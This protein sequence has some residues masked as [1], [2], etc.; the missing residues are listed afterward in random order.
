VS[1]KG[2]EREREH[3]FVTN[4]QE[5]SKLLSPTVNFL[6]PQIGEKVDDEEEEKALFM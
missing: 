4:Q 6:L 3:G 2:S 5:A 1:E